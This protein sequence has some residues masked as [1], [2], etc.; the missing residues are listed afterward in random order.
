MERAARLMFAFLCLIAAVGF[1]VFP[2]Y[3]NYDSYYSLLWGREVLDL[4]LPTFEGFRIPTEHPLAIVAGAVLALFGD[5]GD[6]LWIA[7]SIGSFLVLVAGVYRLAR[8]AFTPLIGVIAGVLLVSRFDFPFLAVRGYIDVPYMALVVWALVLEVER[9]RRGTAVLVLLALA[10]LLR[11]EGWVLAGVY[12]LWLF[13][14]SSWPERVR[15]AVLAAIGPGVWVLT[16]FVVTGDPLFSLTYTSGFA[17]ELGRSRSLSELPGTLPYFFSNLIKLPVV[18]LAVAGI[19]LSVFLVPR[20]AAIPLVLFASGLGTFILIAGAGASVIERYLILAALGLLVFAAVALGGFTL[21]EPGRARTV[22][23]TLSVLATLGGLAYTLLNVNTTRLQNELAFRGESHDALS[24]V[25]RSKAV[26][27]ARRC[28]PLTL[29]NHKLVPEARWIVDAPYA[30]VRARAEYYRR[31]Q[32]QP[33]GG[34]AIVATSRTAIF[35]NAWTD[36]SD[37]ALVESPPA[38]WR[39]VATSEH[40]AAY[41]SC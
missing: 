23:T 29:P 32:P 15:Y 26:R 3:P 20:R 18:L 33:E 13:P 19:V 6:R 10:G 37:P 11:P 2:T 21:L 39:R 24:D 16:D 12:W 8:H 5:V 25:L 14:P 35:K 9:R 41:A 34:V 36:E 4:D 1:F 17:E 31:E 40:Y 28:G 30:P 7:M 27:D 38:G 22:W